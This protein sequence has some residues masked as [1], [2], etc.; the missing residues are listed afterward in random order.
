[1]SVRL[2]LSNDAGLAALPDAA[3]DLNCI[4]PGYDF[5]ALTMTDTTSG[6]NLAWG[7]RNHSYRRSG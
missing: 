1:M 6:V 4:Y 3:F 2:L 7:V 5:G